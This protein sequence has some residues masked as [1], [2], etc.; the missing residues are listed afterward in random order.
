ME[1]DLVVEAPDMCF[2]GC[3]LKYHYLADFLVINDTALLS[4]LLT[5]LHCCH[6]YR[7]SYW[8]P[9]DPVVMP[10]DTCEHWS[11]MKVKVNKPLCVHYNLLGLY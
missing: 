3:Q 5:I 2:S 4:W 10:L 7:I 1:D 6:G 11:K 8:S 9:F